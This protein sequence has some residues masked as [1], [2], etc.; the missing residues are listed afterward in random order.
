MHIEPA[1]IPTLSKPLTPG[2]PFDLNPTL[3]PVD[4]HPASPRLLLSLIATAVYL[5]LPAVA[6]QALAA[7]L[8]SVGPRTVVRYLNFACGKGIGSADDD[9]PEAAVGMERV[10]QSV[11]DKPQAAASPPVADFPAVAITPLHEDIAKS[12]ITPL[13]NSHFQKEG[14][15]DSGSDADEETDENGDH[16]LFFD[17]GAVS[18]KIGEAAACWLARWGADIF[19]Y[20]GRTN[21]GLLVSGQSEPGPSKRR[22]TVNSRPSFSDTASEP[23]VRSPKIWSRGGLSA[24]WASA[25]LSSDLLFVRGERERYD[26]AKSV[27]ELRRKDG[28]LPDEEAEWSNLFKHGIYYTNMV[29]SPNFY[30]LPY[31][32]YSDS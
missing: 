31:A 16:E 21:G 1:L 22:A 6:S 29:S 4:H 7:V 17:Y 15:G 20:E 9:E 8:G 10:A 5:S 13:E 28:L 27:V 11:N 25:V 3:V 24:K 23:S 2:F 14:P 18:N 30:F 32:D 26:L 19:S 12:P